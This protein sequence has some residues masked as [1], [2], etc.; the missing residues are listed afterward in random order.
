MQCENY[1][2]GQEEN[3]ITLFFCRYL[4]TFNTLLYPF[5]AFEGNK[6]VRVKW[7]KA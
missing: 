4:V 2:L 6:V 3:S 5:S 1:L 7:S